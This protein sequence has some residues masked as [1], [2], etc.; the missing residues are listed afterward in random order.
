MKNSDLKK[1]RERDTWCWECGSESDLVPHHRA[2]RGF[3]GSKAL[4]TLQNIIL[5]CARF[6]GEME[7]DAAVANWA[8]DNGMKLSKFMSPSQ[9]VFDNWQKKWFYLDERG[10]KHETEPP[11]FLI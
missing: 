11:S 9:P 8:R 2:N 1:L 5:V 4:D 6:N 3:G 10:N 7:S